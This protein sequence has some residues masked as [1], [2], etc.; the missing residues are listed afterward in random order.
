MFYAYIYIYILESPS[1][2]I[3]AALSCSLR[4]D[5]NTNVPGRM[6][7]LH[8]TL[9]ASFVSLFSSCS[10][11]SDDEHPSLFWGRY[12]QTSWRIAPRNSARRCC[13]N[14]YQAIIFWPGS[15]PGLKVRPCLNSLSHP[16][17]HRPPRLR[18]PALTGYLTSR[19]SLKPS[20]VASSGFWLR[21]L[22]KGRANANCESPLLLQHSSTLLLHQDEARG[23]RRH[24]DSEEML[25]L[26]P[27]FLCLGRSPQT[28][29]LLLRPRTQRRKQHGLPTRFSSALQAG[30]AS[31]PV[32]LFKLAPSVATDRA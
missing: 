22:S 31:L 8:A 2:L 32:C 16:E 12:R 7:Y 17:Q 30:Q 13:C 15:E 24:T 23:R 25:L 19:L 26:F 9:D 5:S 21:C 14:R 6:Y 28:N 11:S 18:P 4:P 10:S 3:T 1:V 29:T 20:P 27:F